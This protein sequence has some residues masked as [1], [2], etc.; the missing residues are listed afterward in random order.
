MKKP[1]VI[2]LR[3]ALSQPSEAEQDPTSECGEVSTN[4]AITT[5]NGKMRI[6]V[7]ELCSPKEA[8]L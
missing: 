1:L 7:A 8:N 3:H 6:A 2:V 5:M 4:N